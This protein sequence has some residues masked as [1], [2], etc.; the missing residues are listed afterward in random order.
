M[1]L[2][3]ND[4]CVMIEGEPEKDL[5]QEI[6]QTGNRTWARWVRSNYVTSMPQR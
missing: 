3:L 5:V 2:E 1:W 4:I 6:E